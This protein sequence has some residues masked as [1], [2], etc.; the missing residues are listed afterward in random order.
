VDR[1]GK[2]LAAIVTGIPLGSESDADLHVLP[3]HT[4]YRGEW[5]SAQNH[6][7]VDYDDSG[8]PHTWHWPERE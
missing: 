4:A 6:A 8:K 2:H 3:H 7:A 1:N 5:A